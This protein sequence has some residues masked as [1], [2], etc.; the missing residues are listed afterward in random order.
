MRRLGVLPLVLGLAAAGP[1][2]EPAPP[3]RP[4]PLRL[5]TVDGRPFVWPADPPAPAACIVFVGTDCPIA[6]AYA[7]E[8]ARLAAAYGRKGVV[9]VVAY[10]LP[11]LK[12]AEARRHAQ[13]YGLSCSVIL[14]ANRN[15]ARRLG[16][17]TTPEAV[18]LSA[19]GEV[20][21]RGRIDDRYSR[22]GG[23]RREVPTRHD[24]RDALDAVLAGRPV[25]A[26]WPPAVGC[27]IW[28][29]E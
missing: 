22:P 26:P 5:T 27:D 1:A 9:F 6:N 13:E 3:P 16:A 29:D 7:P 15:L 12:P 8:I 14:D 18:V 10:P 19:R 28:F 11:D 4:A 2:V 20:V 23:P 25:P 21:Y 17:A 24:L